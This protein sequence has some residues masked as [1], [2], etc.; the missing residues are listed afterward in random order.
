MATIITSK[1][2]NENGFVLCKDLVQLW[3]PPHYPATLHDS[4]FGLL[5]NYE[6]IFRSPLDGEKRVLI[7]S[8][9]NELQPVLKDWDAQSTEGELER[10]YCFT[11]LPLGFISKLILRLLHFTEPKVLWRT[12][13]LLK[14]KETLVLLTSSP[15]NHSV[16]F[17]IRGPNP[18]A[19][20][21]VS[22]RAVFLTAFSSQI[23]RIWLEKM[24]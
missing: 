19:L 7:P 4:L 14:K 22:A 8:L 20:L 11:F 6:L 5:E 9:L 18:S 2:R 21:E 13:A 1:P 17:A 15:L 10:V 23:L 12:G 3:Q 16:T 24:Q